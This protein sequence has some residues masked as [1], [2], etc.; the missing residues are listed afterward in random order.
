[1]IHYAAAHARQIQRELDT[2]WL[3]RLRKGP[4]MQYLNSIFV[5]L[6]IEGSFDKLWRGTMA[7]LTT[8]R[9]KAGIIW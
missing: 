3:S 8:S 9:S 6:L 1:M 4:G 7:M 5:N 2:F